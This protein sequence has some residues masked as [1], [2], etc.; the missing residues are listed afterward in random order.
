MSEADDDRDPS[1]EAELVRTRSR[2]DGAEARF[3]FVFDC[4]AAPMWIEDLSALTGLIGELRR[5]PK[6][7]ASPYFRDHPSV[8]DEAASVIRIVDANPASLRMFGVA[9]LQELLGVRRAYLV[10]EGRQV[11]ARQLVAIAE[12]QKKFI[13][14]AAVT[15]LSGE[16][17]EASIT[18]LLPRMEVLDRVLVTARPVHGS[19]RESDPP[20][21]G[22]DRSVGFS[23]A[24]VGVLGHDLRN[25]LSAITTAAALLESRADS[26]K[27]SKPVGRI[28]ASADRMERMISQLLDFTR[29]RLGGGIQLAC[30]RVSLDDIARAAVDDLESVH[31]TQIQV[32]AK[33]DVVGFWDGDRIGQLVATLGANACQHGA[34]D[35]SVVV[36]L[37]GTSAAAVRIEVSNAGVI[38]SE[39]FPSIFEPFRPS[40]GK[41]GRGKGASGLGLGLFIARQIVLA[42]GGGIDATCGEDGETR[43]SVDLPRQGPTNGDSESS[44]LTEGRA[45]S[46]REMQ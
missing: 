37:D 38:P 46:T 11:L 25:P 30:A 21:S 34:A 12:G 6:E 42:H 19:A 7:E 28:L 31:R 15:A 44:T 3:H 13:S 5:R 23:D 45:A 1:M 14:D 9:S 4:A 35:G 22:A 16:R 27:I 41:E 2:L 24:F 17:F 36:A 32:D 43:F 26:E 40:L 29:I 20:G 39:R 10:R 18:V 8:L 33:G